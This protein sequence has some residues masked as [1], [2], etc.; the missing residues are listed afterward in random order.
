[1]TLKH[2]VFFLFLFSTSFAFN[3]S[4]VKD[5][6]TNI[7]AGNSFNL[8]YQVCLYHAQN[9]QIV[10]NITGNTTTID[11]GEFIFDKCT[12]EN[13]TK[14]YVCNFTGIV[15]NNPIIGISANVSPYVMPD[16]FSIRTMG[17]NALGEVA[18]CPSITAP[19]YYGSSSGGGGGGLHTPPKPVANN[20][21]KPEPAKPAEL[22]K[23][24]VEPPK[25]ITNTTAQ[26]T[27]WPAF[28]NISEDNT[29]AQIDNQTVYAILPTSGIYPTAQF[30]TNGI[31]L[32]Y[33]GVAIA[34]VF[35]AWLVF[36]RGSKGK[37][38]EKVDWGV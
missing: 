4:I 1:M 13:D 34:V 24:V 7:T 11:G 19:I 5:F 28:P 8:Q 25:N 36:Q 3:L 33:F 22:T 14:L 18:G 20:T 2:L 31:Y 23:P 35:G 21:T 6:P 15:G 27:S 26:N 37:P 16:N 38:I 12:W 17:Y 9:Y 10:F 30:D 29:T 32:I